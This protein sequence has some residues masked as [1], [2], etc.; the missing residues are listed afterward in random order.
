MAIGI[1]EAPASKIDAEIG[2]A[3]IDL[4]SLDP[5][6]SNAREWWMSGW[7]FAAA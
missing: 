3:L 2:L 4:G 1:S 6:I 7:T 5:L